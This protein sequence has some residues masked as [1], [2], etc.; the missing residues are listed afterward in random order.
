MGT[1]EQKLKS[2]FT[3]IWLLSRFKPGT[4]SIRR[5]RETTATVVTLQNTNFVSSIFRRFIPSVSAVNN[6]DRCNLLYQHNMYCKEYQQR[7]VSTLKAIF[8]LSTQ[9]CYELYITLLRHC[10]IQFIAQFCSQ[11]EDGL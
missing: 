5:R 6:T 2:L 10:N 7:H 9:L 3:R 11:P 8:C 4:S 1:T